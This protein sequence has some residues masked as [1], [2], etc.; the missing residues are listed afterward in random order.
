MLRESFF[1]QRALFR[2]YG[3]NLPPMEGPR[4]VFLLLLLGA[5]LM[6]LFALELALGP[7]GLSPGEVWNAMVSPDP[8]SP[9]SMIVRSSRLPRAITAALA[10]A[11]LSACG[12]IMQTLF[13]NPLAS[14]S[15]LGISS[16]ASLG[17]AVFILGSSA[18]GWYTATT[19]GIALSAIIGAMAVLTLVLIVARRLNDNNALLI[20]G[21]MLGQFAGAVESILQFNSSESALRSFTLWGM[22]S[23]AQAQGMDLLWL[24]A[25]VIVLMA[26]AFSQ[27]K[28]LNV[29]LFGEDQ[30]MLTGV[31]VKCLRRG[32]IGVT[33]VATGIVTAFCGPI[34]FIGLTVPHAVRNII[35]TAHH[36]KL[37]APVLMSGACVGLLADLLSRLADW[38]LN[39]VTSALGAPVIILLLF[40]KNNRN[41]VSA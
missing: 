9:A 33:G 13:R 34:A 31:R 30:A 39:A 1:F 17:T 20:F 37:I 14:P 18:F 19:Y 26:F 35:R 16:G 36:G 4:T 25:A 24:L 7:V 12:L 15:I 38:P 8:M 10:G 22:G 21:I 40:R 5:L 2:F 27:Y 6:V 28:A 11:A 3:S 41:F 32:I 23:F 29:L